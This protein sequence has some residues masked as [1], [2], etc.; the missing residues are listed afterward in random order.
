AIFGPALL[1]EDGSV[2]QNLRRRSVPWHEILELLPASR[3]WVPRGL[4]RDLAASDPRYRDGGEVDYLQ[5]AC[6]AIDRER[7][8]AIGGFDEDFFLYS[9][10]EALC[11]AVIGAGGRCVYM[12]AVEVAHVGATSTVAVR[13]FALRHS[14]RSKAILYRKRYGELQGQ[15][16][17]LAIA[18]AAI[19]NRML[20][21]LAVAGGASAA[22][23]PRTQ[24]DTL[25][26]L[27]DGASHRIG[28]L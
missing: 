20:Y 3:R 4:R 15:L 2:R 25:R 1:H 28:R 16:F 26:G 24:G 7:F 22:R 18:L 23:L 9:E 21:P 14:Y 8:L 27:L 17:V 13:R 19:L 5:G 12:P 11:E 6:L 10:E